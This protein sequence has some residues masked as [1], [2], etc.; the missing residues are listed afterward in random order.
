[1]KEYRVLTEHGSGFKKV[2]PE[3]LEATLNKHAADGWRV[4]NSFSVFTI[5]QNSSITTV[6]ER[7][8]SQ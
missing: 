5:G 2:V 3:S 4:V 8:A 6:M 7:D 1:M